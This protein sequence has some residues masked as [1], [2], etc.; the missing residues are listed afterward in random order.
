MY[1]CDK[2]GY[3]TAR[4]FNFEKHKN[5]KFKCKGPNVH[6]VGPNVHSVGP[7]VHSVG[8][9]VHSVGPNVHSVGPNVH[10][11]G[12]NVHS[13]GSNV[14]SA[15]SN[16]HSA[17]SNVHSG[18]K[19]LSC[20]KSFKTKKSL[21][22][23]STKCNGEISILQCPN[24]KVTF[25]SSQSKCNHIKRNNCTSQVQN[26]DHSITIN[27]HD[28]NGYINNLTNSCNTIINVFGKEDLSHLD[29]A[30][31]IEKTKQL[32]KKGVYGLV[33]LIN[34]IYFDPNVPQNHNI[35]KMDER[36]EDLFI[37]TEE[38]DWEFRQ[39]DDIRTDM[40]ETLVQHMKL[41]ISKKNAMNIRL[42][43]PKEQRLIKKFIIVLLTV[44]GLVP[45]IICDEF[46]VDN[47][48]VEDELRINQKFDK[49]TLYNLFTKSKMNYKKID[50]KIKRV[51]AE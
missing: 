23:H 14:H 17:G 4:K 49:A 18:D 22:L 16:V 1:E 24:C 2:C 29:N 40:V 26:T 5:R 31:I 12:S 6:S 44:G 28:N 9:N 20:H 36:S 8:P 13:V 38:N 32:G 10:S 15:G 3:N 50:G 33:D 43:E 19:C 7:N 41:Y 46:N 25:S 34:S 42:T 37:K 30:S 51:F 45:D 27:L 21:K 47:D 48:D 11:V 39:F 35:A